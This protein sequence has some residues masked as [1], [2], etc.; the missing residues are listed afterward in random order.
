MSPAYHGRCLI[1]KK[2]HRHVHLTTEHVQFVGTC[3]FAAFLFTLDTLYVATT[4]LKR[5]NQLAVREASC[6][7]P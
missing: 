2:Q 5:V 6:V 7:G 1:K 3:N 4:L